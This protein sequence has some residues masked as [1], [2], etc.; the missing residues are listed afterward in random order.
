[1][2]PNLSNILEL[3]L[4][5]TPVILKLESPILSH[6]LL[7][8]NE[9]GLEFQLFDLDPLPES[10]STPKSLLDLNHFPESVLV[11]VF[12]KSKSIILSFHTPFWDKA[13]DKINSE[14]NY[15]I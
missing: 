2:L 10:I 7:L 1:M 9:C 6:I 3:V 15:E 8:G 14:I 4:V 12:L 13:I 5:P 11:P